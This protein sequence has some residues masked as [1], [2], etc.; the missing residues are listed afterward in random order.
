MTRASR[1][2]I[3]TIAIGITVARSLLEMLLMS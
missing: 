1:I 2:P 3:T